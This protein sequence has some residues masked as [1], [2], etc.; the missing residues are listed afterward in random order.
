MS[1]FEFSA[2]CVV[3]EHPD[4]VCHLVGFADSEFDTELYLMLQRS[5][6]DEE[7]DVRLGQDTYHV[8][9][10]DQR[11][12]GYG[13]IQRFVLKPQSIEVSGPSCA[14]DALR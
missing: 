8:E 9:W 12:S 7:Q 5:F 1:A 14:P 11:T 13:G 4:G 6:V 2:N 3:T 10:C